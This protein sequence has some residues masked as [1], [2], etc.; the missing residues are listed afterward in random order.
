MKCE[1]RIVFKYLITLALKATGRPTLACWGGYH[2]HTEQVL[3]RES[4]CV[5]QN[6]KNAINFD[7]SVDIV[8]RYTTTSDIT[9]KSDDNRNS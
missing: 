9:V 2:S 5:R 3:A 4:V 6:D 1:L 7:S 8:D